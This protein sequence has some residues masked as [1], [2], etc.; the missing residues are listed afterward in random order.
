MK[1]FGR[2]I[3]V[4]AG[5]VLLAASAFPQGEKEGQGQIIVTILP[6]HEG[7]AAPAVSTQTMTVKVNGK[8]SRVTSLKPLVDTKDPVELAILIDGSARSSLAR[9]FN[10]IEEFVK[11]LPPSVRTTI[12]YMQNGRTTLAGGFTADHATVLRGLHI[13]VGSAGSNGSP[14]FCLSDLAKSWPSQDRAARREVL[15]IT[16]GVDEFNRRYDPDDPYV[17]AAIS[18]AARARLVVYSIYWRNQGRADNT[19]YENNAGQN[20]LVE[21]T[22]AT[23]GKSFWQGSGNPVSF[24][25]YFEELS[26]RLRNQYELSFLVPAKGKA[27]VEDVKLKFKLPGTEVDAPQRVFVAVPGVVQE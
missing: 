27:E 3:C 26:R 21:L 24:Q 14:Y 16:D 5:M 23:G 15:M 19:Q 2:A 8:E 25:P 13:P 1:E 18:D 11:S 6:K 9:Q 17:Q 22:D 4:A 7:D 12:G 20:L 10:D